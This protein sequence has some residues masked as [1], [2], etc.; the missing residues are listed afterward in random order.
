MASAADS[1]LIAA[2]QLGNSCSDTLLNS[3]LSA[4]F[5]RLEDVFFE[6]LSLAV[7]GTSL[8]PL[9][10]LMFLCSEKGTDSSLLMSWVRQF[11]CG[12]IGG[13]TN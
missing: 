2:D 3:P 9:S 10:D 7:C 8:C 6:T 5:D 1:S 4:I 13:Y 11:V 12:Y